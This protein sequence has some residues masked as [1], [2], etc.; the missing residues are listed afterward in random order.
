[1]GLLKTIISESDHQMFQLFRRTIIK[2]EDVYENKK[3]IHIFFRAKRAHAL[4]IVHQLSTGAK[5]RGVDYWNVEYLY[6]SI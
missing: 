1:M 3:K 5:R 6:K 2:C 4:A